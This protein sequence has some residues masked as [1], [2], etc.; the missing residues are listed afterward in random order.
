MSEDR[1][2][3]PSLTL[4]VHHPEV[5]E[6][7]VLS[8]GNGVV[9]DIGTYPT[10]ITMFFNGHGEFISFILDLLL[11]SGID[12]FEFER[13][14]TDYFVADVSFGDGNHQ[15]FC[16]EG[17]IADGERVVAED[18][19]AISQSWQGVYVLPPVS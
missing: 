5:A 7:R 11:K 8:T 9:V 2:P 15:P 17:F 18:D 14:F 19:D 12:A 4:N 6:F 1:K 16:D 10:R 3:T 13:P